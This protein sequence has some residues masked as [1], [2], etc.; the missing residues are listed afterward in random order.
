MFRLARS[1]NQFP[2][3]PLRGKRGEK[4]PELGKWGGKSSKGWRV[5]LS[6]SVDLC[7]CFRNSLMFEAKSCRIAWRFPHISLQFPHIFKKSTHRPFSPFTLSLSLK[8]L[9][10]KKNIDVEGMYI[11]KRLSTNCA[12]QDIPFPHI[13]TPSTPKCVEIRGR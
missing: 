13:F 5:G 6:K 8:F 7:S 1:M 10:R 2:P 11:S 4:K 3:H 12:F 9:K